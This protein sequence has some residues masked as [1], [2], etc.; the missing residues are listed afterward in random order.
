MPIGQNIKRLR[1]QAGIT[2]TQLAEKM[3]VYGSGSISQWESGFCNPS[4]ENVKK[5]AEIL[6]V[7]ANDILY[8]PQD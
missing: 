3:G 4:L 1:N 6:G 7:T 2:Q 5:I 8:D